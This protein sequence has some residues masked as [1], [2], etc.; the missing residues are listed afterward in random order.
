MRRF[1]SL[2]IILCLGA[3]TT[4]IPWQP[5]ELS[6][7][8]KVTRE[9]PQT[10]HRCTNKAADR[11]VRDLFVTIIAVVAVYNKKGQTLTTQGLVRVLTRDQKA[12]NAFLRAQSV[13]LP[14]V[15]Y[16]RELE[17]QEEENIAAWG[18]RPYP[19]DYPMILEAADDWGETKPH[20]VSVHARGLTLYCEQ[21]THVSRRE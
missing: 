10:W 6:T 14:E 16:F 18:E 17:P 5:V 2:A 12:I 20:L 3:C 9:R 13:I 15:W 21:L 7:L 4:T 11:Y 19:G 1:I 8:S